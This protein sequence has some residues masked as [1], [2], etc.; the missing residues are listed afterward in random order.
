M[1]SVHSLHSD[2][3]SAAVTNPVFDGGDATELAVLATS[4]RVAIISP[5]GSGESRLLPTPEYDARQ[6]HAGTYITVINAGSYSFTLKQGAD[7]LQEVDEGESVYC[8]LGVE[9]GAYTWQ[10]SLLSHVPAPTISGEGLG[11]DIVST[12]PELIAS[13]YENGIVVPAFGDHIISSTI[14]TPNRAGLVVLGHGSSWQDINSSQ[15]GS[16]TFVTWG[17]SN[18]TTPMIDLRGI[19]SYWSNMALCGDNKTD[20][21]GGAPIAGFNVTFDEGLG[22]GK[23][24]WDNI[25][26]EKLPVGIKFGEAFGDNNCDSGYAMNCRWRQCSKGI[27]VVNGQSLDTVLTH[28]LWESGATD[29]VVFHYEAGGDLTVYQLTVVDKADILRLEQKNFSGSYGLGSNRAMFRIHDMKTDSQANGLTL[30]HCVT[31]A[32]YHN[33]YDVNVLF[34]GALISG[35]DTYVSGGDYLAK[36]RGGCRLTVRDSFIRPGTQDSILVNNTDST[37]GPVIIK[38]YDCVLN[39]LTTADDIIDSANSDGSVRLVM[40]GCVTPGGTAIPDYD[41]TLSL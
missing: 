33:R 22:S 8:V 23:H 25:T 4:G 17:T 37:V 27:Y 6:I 16:Y 32:S 31:G 14:V 35:D 15:L 41:E 5:A 2:L 1:G 7:T 24:T 20:S 10:T 13:A 39:G 36:M 28:C 11:S 21:Y 12:L 29:P 40:K 38:F 9:D 18:T 3:Y 34:T 19:N 26:F 30:L